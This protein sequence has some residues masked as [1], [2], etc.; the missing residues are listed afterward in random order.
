MEITSALKTVAFFLL[1]TGAFAQQ[2]VADIRATGA[3]SGERQADLSSISGTVVAADTR[4]PLKKVS[5]ML[6]PA[7]GQPNGNP[8]S[9]TTTDATGHYVL[10]NIEAGRYRLSAF[11]N[12]YVRQEYGATRAN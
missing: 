5:V 6:M 12:G 9:S 4:E 1:A 10:K 8:R 7:D 11:R 3:T 2:Q